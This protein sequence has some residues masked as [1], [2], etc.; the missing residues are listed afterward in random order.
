VTGDQVQAAKSAMRAR[1]LAARAARSEA[2]CAEVAT[3][4]AGLFAAFLA[5]GSAPAPDEAARGEPAPTEAARGGPM[6][7]LVAAYLSIGAEP[8][9][10]LLLNTLA[11]LGVRVIVPVLTADA[12]LD[13]TP[14]TAGDPVT[15]GRHGTLEPAGPRLGVDAIAAAAIVLTPALAVDRAGRRLG[16]GG[17]SYDRALARV[18]ADRFVFAVVHDDEVVDEVPVQPHDQLVD[19]ALTPGGVLAFEPRPRG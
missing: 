4:L 19:G 11:A 5:G 13:W 15:A 7:D 12:D 3:A 2:A 9:T 14:Y 16:R 6:P 17:G 1:Q 18:P 10:T 8:S